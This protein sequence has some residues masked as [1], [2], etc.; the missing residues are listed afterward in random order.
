MF[1]G[2][3]LHI[4]IDGTGVSAILGATIKLPTST[5]KPFKFAE[6][7]DLTSLFAFMNA[8]VDISGFVP[9]KA[10]SLNSMFAFYGN[11]QSNKQSL[12]VMHD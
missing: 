7:A 6:G 5:S 8:N 9:N 12:I 4:T 10:M 11:A 2:Y 1:A 3:N